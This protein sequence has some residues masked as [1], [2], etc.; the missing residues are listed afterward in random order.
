ML[1]LANLTLARGAKRL[2]EGASLTV[3]VGHKV[4]LIGANGSGKSSV[5][6]LIRGELLAEA[7]E[8]WIPPGWTIAH[9]APATPPVAT[10]AIEFVLDGDAELRAI[11]RA[12]AE[13]EAAHDDDPHAAGATLAELHHRF[14]AIGG[15]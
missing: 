4:G 8:M 1:R 13:S 7:G 3:H 9:V 5:F 14:E 12:L 15:Y 10:P 6:A 11:E 2:L